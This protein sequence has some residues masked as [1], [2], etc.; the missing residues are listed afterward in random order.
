MSNQRKEWT[1]Y[2]EAANKWIEP[3][4]SRNELAALHAAGTINDYTQVVNTRTARSRAPGGGFDGVMYSMLGHAIDIQFKPV[5][6]APQE[7]V[8]CHTLAHLSRP[9]RL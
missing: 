2:D 5:L 6:P 9:L 1:Y 8:Y 4:V 7:S 3:H